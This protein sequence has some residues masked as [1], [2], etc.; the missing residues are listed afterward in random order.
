MNY[1]NLFG[2]ITAILT[3][4]TGVMTQLLGCTTDAMGITTCSSTLLPAKYMAIAASVFGVVTIVSKLMRPGGALHSLF[5]Q[6]AVVVDKANTV[7]GTVT[8][9]QV[10]SK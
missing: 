2:T 5:G 3:V 7:P 9:A 6:T 10:A 4:L 8:K 1:T